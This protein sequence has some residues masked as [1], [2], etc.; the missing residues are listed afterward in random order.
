MRQV[1]ISEAALEMIRSALSGA[2]KF[3]AEVLVP[4]GRLLLTAQQLGCSVLTQP[5]F[6]SCTHRGARITFSRDEYRLRPRV[7]IEKPGKTISFQYELAPRPLD[8]DECLLGQFLEMLKLTL[9]VPPTRKG[10]PLSEALLL[11]HPSD[12]HAILV[13]ELDN[14]TK[15]KP[16]ES[17]FE[18]FV[19]L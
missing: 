18:V 4:N 11:L 16:A 17:G 8:A 2:G 19:D 6:V 12:P 3:P 9:P 10:I 7:V 5:S 13:T 14:V 15:V 1:R